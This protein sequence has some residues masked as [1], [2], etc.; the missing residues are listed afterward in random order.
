MNYSKIRRDDE[1]VVIYGSCKGNTGKV[2]EVLRKKNR[3]LVK[4]VNIISRHTKSSAKVSGGI[5]K[6]ESPIHISNVSLI[7]K[8]TNK[9]TKIGFKVV[10]NG[11]KVR[12]SKVSGD[13]IN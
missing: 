5:L 12:Y 2:L 13:I 10:N 4:G 3:V 8:K 11:E 9:P 6:K 1:V 7:D